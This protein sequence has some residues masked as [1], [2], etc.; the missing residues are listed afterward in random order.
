L[1]VRVSAD[2]AADSF[3]AEMC[4]LI[5]VRASYNHQHKQTS[6]H[7]HRHHHP[8]AVTSTGGIFKVL[9]CTLTE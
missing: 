9:K 8:Q 2:V 4:R 1:P 5:S 3:A 7:H 6:L